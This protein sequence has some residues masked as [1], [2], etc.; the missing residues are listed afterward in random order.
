MRAAAEKAGLNG[1]CLY[2]LRHS[3]ITQRL[4]AG[5]SALEVARITGTFLAMIE[6]HYGHL[7]MREARERL[8]RVTLL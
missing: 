5:M 3:F 7:V 1:V 2:A 6:K 8:D 4:M